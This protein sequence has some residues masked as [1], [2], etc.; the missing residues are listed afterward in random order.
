MELWLPRNREVN[1][2][3][4]GLNRSASADISTFNGSR[5]CI[6]SMQLK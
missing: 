3:I 4:E 1:L 6:T 2:N 5:T